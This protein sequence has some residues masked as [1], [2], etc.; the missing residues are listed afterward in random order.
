MRLSAAIL[1][2]LLPC[3]AQAMTD[4]EAR[5]HARMLGDILGA[6]QHCDLTYDQAAIAA[7]IEATIPADRLDFA[8]TVDGLA[9]LARFTLDGQSLSQ[10]TAFCTSIRRAAAHLGFI[11][12]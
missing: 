5:R 2:A 1:V 3:A 9:N 4:E 11:T 6:E 12:P 8:S 10:R 7:W